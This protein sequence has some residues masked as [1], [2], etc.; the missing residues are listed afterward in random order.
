MERVLTLARRGKMKH[1]A[2]A[3]NA[4]RQDMHTA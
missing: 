2:T 4:K 3:M 1:D